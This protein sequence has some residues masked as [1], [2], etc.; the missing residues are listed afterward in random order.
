MNRVAVFYARFVYNHQLF[1]SVNY[2]PNVYHCNAYIKFAHSRYS[3]AQT[4]TLLEVK[5]GCSQC[6]VSLF[7]TICPFGRA[8]GK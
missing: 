1:S 4:H 3:F 6:N 7:R 2:V 5:L 8:L